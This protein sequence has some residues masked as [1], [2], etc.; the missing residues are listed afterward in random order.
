MGHQTRNSAI[1]VDERVYPCLPVM[2]RCCADDQFSFARA[3]IDFLKSFPE[4]RHRAETNGAK[5]IDF[6]EKKRW[7]LTAF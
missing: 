2:R 3:T 6:R 5:G 4:A 7:R 1:S